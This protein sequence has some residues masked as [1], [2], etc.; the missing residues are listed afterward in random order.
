MNLNKLIDY[1]SAFDGNEMTANRRDFQ[2][3]PE[4]SGLN[5]LL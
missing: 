1:E 2:K 3:N 5:G 4:N